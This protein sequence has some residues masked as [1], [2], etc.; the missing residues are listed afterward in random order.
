MPTDDRLRLDACL[1]KCLG[2]DRH[3]PGDLKCGVDIDVKDIERRSTEAQSFEE[4]AGRNC[5]PTAG[6]NLFA[7]TDL[8]SRRIVR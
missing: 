5:T 7:S 3:E 8:R 2:S 6:G 1:P 4:I